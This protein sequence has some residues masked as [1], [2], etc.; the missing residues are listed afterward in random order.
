MCAEE[1][2]D[3]ANEVTVV[4]GERERRERE[5]ERERGREK[6]TER[7]RETKSNGSQH[8]TAVSRNALLLPLYYMGTSLIRTLSP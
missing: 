7:D 3:G 8:V 5:I 4:S 2:L 6:E 1:L